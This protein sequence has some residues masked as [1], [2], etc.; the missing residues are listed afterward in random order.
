MWQE[1]PQD[2]TELLGENARI[3]PLPHWRDEP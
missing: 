1:H 2:L 3:A